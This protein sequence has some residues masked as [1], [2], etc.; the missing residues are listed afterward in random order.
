MVIE[1]FQ[2]RE[3]TEED[4]PQ[5]SNVIRRAMMPEVQ[6]RHFSDEAIVQSFAESAPQALAERIEG[7]YFYVA[8]DPTNHKIIGV[9]GLKK[10]IGSTTHNRV[11]TFDVDP[12]FQHKGVGRLLYQQAEAQASSLGCKKLSVSS[13]LM[14]EPIYR[15]WGFNK[16]REVIYDYG[17]GNRYVN[18]WME[19]DL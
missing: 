12:D 17:Q 5:V 4:L 13:S 11:S 2:V 14:A 1:T 15:R 7:N 16:I 9:I 6:K 18:I 3:I 19:K 8:T 10:D